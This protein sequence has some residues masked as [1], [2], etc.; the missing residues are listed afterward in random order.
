MEANLNEQIVKPLVDMNY[1]V[2][3]GKYPQFKFKAL[4][5]EEKQS[6]FDAY[7][8]GV[9]SKALTKTREDENFQRKRLGMPLLPEDHPVAGE[10]TP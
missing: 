3:D 4:M 5:A 8:N 2:T 1:D 7:I 10:V 6:Q 9:K